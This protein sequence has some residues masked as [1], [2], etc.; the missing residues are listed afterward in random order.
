[1]TRFFSL[2]FSWCYRSVR[3]LLSLSGGL[4]AAAAARVEHGF[5]LLRS[6]WQV[7]HEWI[8]PAGEDVFAGRIAI[9]A[10]HDKRGK[11]RSYVLAHLAGLQEAGCQILFVSNSGKLDDAAMAA[12]QPYCRQI[13]VRRNLGGKWGA[14]REA[15]RC[16]PEDSNLNLLILADDSSYGPFLPLSP[17][18]AD[19]DFSKADIRS[20]TDSWRQRWHLQSYFLAIHPRVLRHAAWH[21]FWAGMAPVN[22]RTWHYRYGEVGF[23]QSL[24]RA[25][26]RLQPRS[27]F[28]A[29]CQSVAHGMI[30]PD[31][32][33]HGRALDPVMTLWLR[34]NQIQQ[35]DHLMASHYPFD[36]THMLWRELL[37]G[38]HPYLSRDLLRRN[39]EGVRDLQDC[40]NEIALISDYDYAAIEADQRRRRRSFG[41]SEAVVQIVNFCIKAFRGVCRRVDEA[42]SQ[43][44][45]H[46][47]SHRQARFVWPDAPVKCGPRVVVF[48]HFD[49][50]GEVRPYVLHYLNALRDAGVSILF[51]SNSGKLKP[52]AIE[53]LKPLC[54]GIIVRRNIGYD[55]GAWREGLEY[56]KGSLDRLE[57]LAIANDSL[58]GPLAPLG[59]LFDEMNFAAADVWGLTDS[60]QRNWHLQSY[61]V[62]FSRR[63]LRSGAWRRFWRGILPVKSKSWAISHGEIA[64]TGALRAAGFKCAA[65]FPYKRLL[66][67]F[68]P[69]ETSDSGLASP[70]L[71]LQWQQQRNVAYAIKMGYSL[72]P[73]AELWRQLLR[74][75]FP[76]LKRELL[77]S[78][79][80]D[81]PDSLDWQSEVS[82]A[83]QNEVRLIEEDLRRSV[84]GRVA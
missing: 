50:Y 30:Q 31:R 13:L 4:I 14:W 71:R 18:I 74:Q 56:L 1:M 72:N 69:N 24:I 38:G 32:P 49:R 54:I 53:S 2:S 44:V 83:S 82:A 16:I 15:L 45:S 8:A 6:P 48:V 20:L 67:E 9:F 77:R 26:L 11:V 70:L 33:Q 42:V 55:F 21:K 81:V 47:R 66:A 58:Y 43:I 46:L 73:T 3:G 52:L 28:Y 37:A 78:N 5:S 12:L 51:V 7:T 62:A 76:F 59:P 65:L 34:Y 60:T 35:I 41:L 57:W 17:V 36:P 68:D 40:P 27:T 84:R 80:T 63:V 19:L 23:S 29:L 79:P 61:F 22:S 10:H 25:G 64:I 39:P 75:G